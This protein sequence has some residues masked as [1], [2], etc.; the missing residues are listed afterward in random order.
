[1]RN[2]SQTDRPIGLASVE[3][4]HSFQYMKIRGHVLEVAAMATKKERAKQATALSRALKAHRHEHGLTQTA[5]GNAIGVTCDTIWAYE[6]KRSFPHRR[7]QVL[8]A[9]LLGKDVFV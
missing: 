5:M 1:M 2:T 3:A 9:E 6:K 4:M 7:R 8:I